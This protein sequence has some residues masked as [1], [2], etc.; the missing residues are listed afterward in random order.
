MFRWVIR[1]V[2]NVIPDVDRYNMTAYVAEGFNISWP[3]MF[4]SVLLLFGYLLPWAVLAY[5]LMKWR[6]V[7]SSDGNTL[8]MA[9]PFQQ[10]ARC[11][12]LQ[13]IWS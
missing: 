7:A 4:V 6:E 8:P 10:Q 2:L 1:Q 11:R 13:Y 3:Q 5:Y 9:S 12:K